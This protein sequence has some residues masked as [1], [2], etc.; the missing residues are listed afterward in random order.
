MYT[1][2]IPIP[3]F[4]F[5][6]NRSSHA[7][8]NPS[9]QSTFSR[10]EQDNIK[11]SSTKSIV[12]GQS[13]GP[14]QHRGSTGIE[15]LSPLWLASKFGAFGT[16]VHPWHPPIL[17]KKL[18]R[19][20]CREMEWMGL[21]YSTG[22]DL[23]TVQGIPAW[24]FVFVAIIMHVK[25]VTQFLWSTKPWKEP[26]KSSRER[27]NIR[28]PSVTKESSATRNKLYSIALVLLLILCDFVEHILL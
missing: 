27:H 2:Y 14:Q 17:L 22:D 18:Q 20:P 6:W 21:K 4:A 5:W 19:H 10:Q 12:L 24:Q 25:Q 15:D 23:S 13:G 26:A 7:V 9:K 1:V 11:Q 8:Q 16:A 28:K 3:P